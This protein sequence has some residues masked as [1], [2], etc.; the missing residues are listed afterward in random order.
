MAPGRHAWMSRALLGA[1][2]VMLASLPQRT[3]EDRAAA[4]IRGRPQGRG[5]LRAR[6]LAEGRAGQGTFEERREALKQCLAREY[7]SFFRPFE[8][9]FYSEEVTFR[10][11][12]NQLRG[13]DSYRNNVEML[14]GE[15]LVGNVLFS[16][17][18]I[19]LH[20][21]EDVP[22]DLTRLRTRW[23]L[24]FVF[25]LLPW[26]PRALFSGVSEYT[27]DR[28]TARV[29]SQRDYW[30]TLSLQKNGAYVPEPPLAG[31]QDLVG[32]LLPEPLRPAEAREP[33]AAEGP[34]WSL[35]RRARAYRVYRDSAARVF[36]VVAPGF[37]SGQRGLRSELEAHGLLPGN[38][39]RLPTGPAGS[40]EGLEVLPPHPWQ[41]D[42]LTATGR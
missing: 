33:Q 29:L 18:F 20:A 3:L 23:T 36:A 27:I 6:R 15:S 21:V 12:L 25:K 37:T 34:G 30:D 7:R 19:D 26:R 13:K 40:V 28:D 42:E 9:E 22:G 8:A 35:L 41:S 4:F 5:Q 38:V 16:D 11:P 39:I 2:V 31:L 32:Q 24:G 1:A 10:D 17:G 14:S